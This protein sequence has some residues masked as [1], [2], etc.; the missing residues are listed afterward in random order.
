MDVEAGVD[1]VIG[2]ETG[3]DIEDEDEGEA[4]SNDRGTMEVGVDVVV[5]IDIPNDMLMPDAI[6][7]LEQL[8]A[9]SLIAS[10]E[11]A[12]L[13]DH[14]AALE[15][16]NA[17]LRGTLMMESARFDRLRG[18]MGFM[19]EL[20]NQRVAE[21]L[22][23]YKANRAAELVVE[24]Q[25]QNR[26]D[27]DNQNDRGMETEMVVE[28][29]TEIKEAMRMEIP[30]GMIEVLCMSPMK[31]YQVKYVTCTLLNSALTWWNAHKRT[32]RADAA[33]SMSWRELMKLMSEMVEEE[34]RVEKFIGGL[35]NNIQGNVIAA[36]PTRLQDVVRIANN[37]INQKLKGYVVRNAENKRMLDK[38]QRDNCGQQPLVKR[39]NFGGQNVARA[40]MK[41]G[42][43]ARD[44]KDIVATTTRGALEPNQKVGTCY[45]CGRQGHYKSDC[46]KLKNQNRGNKTGNKTNKARGKACVLE[47]GEANPDSN[48]VTGAFLLDNRYASMLFD[49]GADRSFVSTTFS[50]LLDVIPS[51]L[52]VSYAVELADGRVAETNIVLRGCT[53]GL[54]GHPFN[55]DLIPVELGSFDVVIGMDWLANHHAVIVCDEEILFPGVAPVARAPYRLAPS[56]MQELSA[57]LQ[58]LCDKGF[59]RPSSSHRGALFH[60]IDDLFDQLQ[61]AKVYFKIDLRSGYHQL[62]VREEDIPNTTFR[63][64]Y[65]HYEFQAMPFGL[66]NAPALFMDLMNPVCKPCLDKFV[67]VFI[68]DILIYSKNK[69]DHEEHLKL[70]LRFIKKEELVGHGFDA[71]G[72]VIAY[73]S[74]QLKIH[75]KNYTTHDLELGVV[76]FALKMWRCYLYDTKCVVFTD[77]N[78]LQHIIDQKK[79]NMRQRRRL[80][81]LS[82]YDCEIRYH[83]KKANVVADALSRKERIKLL[84]KL[85]PRADGTLCL[86]N[87]SWIPCF[88]DL[89]SLIV[90]ESPKSKYSIHSGSDKMYQDLKKLYWWPNMKAEIA[91]YVSKCLTCAKVKAEYQK[92]SGLLVQP[93]IPVWKWENITMDF[94]TK[95]PKTSTGQD[96]IWVIIDCLTKSAY[97]LPI[98]ENDSMEKLTRKFFKEVVTRHGTQL[99]MRT[100]YH[101]QTDGQ[102]ERTI[103]T[104]E[105]MLRACVTNFGKGWDRHLPL[106]EFLYNNSYH[107]SI[108]AAPFKALYGRK[109]R[110]PVCWAEVG[111][112]QL[113][114]P[115]IVHETTEKIIQIKKRIQATRDRQK[116]YANRRRKPLEFQV[117][118]KVLAKVETV[119][120]RL[121]LPDQLSRVHS[122]FHVSNLKKCCFD[123][124]LAIPLDENHIDDKLNFEL[125]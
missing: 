84:R 64:R 63:T 65:G 41:V 119:A 82:D 68:D 44:C 120:Y 20:I 78:S 106:V 92:P 46:P 8:E 89:R 98:K 35:P 94:V 97:F 47:G 116:S 15:R 123:E 104:L 28:I 53:L 2:I 18:R 60:L 22:A 62:R 69:K 77:H 33:F 115:E 105:D 73:A 27:D 37:L 71:N 76:V 100:A 45:E 42:H 9:E 101:P 91:A 66:T 30:I 43:M 24:S 103:Q 4:E 80:E 7:R 1:V 17:R 54:L 14:V 112:A 51:T 81:L 70:I 125:V 21:T 5:R 11:R 55:N 108:K 114:G 95:L 29:E 109:Y 96:T 74:R 6:E 26:D 3:D 72:K 83:P 48:V 52:D 23:T 57:Q 12:G 16:S 99:D 61:G 31:R 118:D 67:I 49:S 59:I 58:E 19:E 93:V 121:E 124:P 113:T 34:D 87:T 32:I 110:S 90:H 117:R 36:E 111:D 10:G 102:S 122:T 39:Q 75:K 86:K 50:A 25:S 13:L 88:C 79:L 85:E 40:Y 56:K 38:N 107:T